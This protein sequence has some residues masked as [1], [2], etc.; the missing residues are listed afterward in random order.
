MRAREKSRIVERYF[1]LS[2][3]DLALFKFILEG[4]DGLATVTTI[5]RHAA[6]VRVSA[7][8]GSAGELDEVIRAVQEEFAFVGFQPLDGD[9]FESE[10]T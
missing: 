3:R 2:S 6:A 1:R 5:D 4:Y 10:E 8:G 7:I 9:V